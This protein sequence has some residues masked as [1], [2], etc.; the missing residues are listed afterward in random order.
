MPHVMANLQGVAVLDESGE[1][2]LVR[3]GRLSVAQYDLLIADLVN[4]L[5]YLGEPGRSDRYRIGFLVMAVLLVLLV[6]SYFLYRDYWRD[7]E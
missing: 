3:P 2:E 4:F 5:D 1:I 6:L 7:I